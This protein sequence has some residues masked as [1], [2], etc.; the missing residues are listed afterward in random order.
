MAEDG[1]ISAQSHACTACGIP[2]EMT[3]A[4]ACAHML[5]KEHCAT[6][7]VSRPEHRTVVVLCC[8][9]RQ[10]RLPGPRTWLNRCKNEGFRASHV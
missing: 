10:G 9:V 4:E 1:E 8:V 5:T 6:A 3:L 2:R 7:K